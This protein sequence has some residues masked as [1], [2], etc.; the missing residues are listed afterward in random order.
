MLPTTILA[1]VALPGMAAAFDSSLIQKRQ[2]CESTGC[3]ECVS[4]CTSTQTWTA[5]TRTV[6]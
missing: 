6:P 4:I 3:S 5:L 1:S 2:D